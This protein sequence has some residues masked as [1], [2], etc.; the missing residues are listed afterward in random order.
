MLIS[1]VICTHNRAKILEKTLQSFLSLDIRALEDVELIVVDN[2]SNDDTKEIFD[3][4][5]NNFVV[6]TRYVFEPV[7]GI[8]N[9]RNRGIRE[10]RG[11]WIAFVDD[12]VYFDRAWLIEIEHTISAFPDA[13]CI[14]GAVL[15][16]YEVA[17]PNW[18]DPD[19]AWLNMES[20]FSITIFGNEARYLAS[21]ETPVGAN[22]AF[23]LAEIRLLDGFSGVLGR[24]GKN[25]LSKEESE[26]YF[27]FNRE[28]FRAVSAPKAIVHHRIPPDR[29]TKNW[30]VRRFYWQGISQAVFDQLTSPRSRMDV[31]KLAITDIAQLRSFLFGDS[32]SPIKIYWQLRSW[33]FYHK[34]FTA[35][36]YALIHKRLLLSLAPLRK[37]AVCAGIPEAH[38]Q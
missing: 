24:H 4:S 22:F 31:F 27:R 13:A 19:P 23:R 38:R 34:V 20:M 32:W 11:Q 33:R 7:L 25:L 29:T 15:P 17:R 9:A 8:S 14:S 12:D 1:V 16:H 18:L 6:D 10:A 30:M 37:S 21:N 2:K 28:G 35:Y 5:V 3:R 36:K 26:L